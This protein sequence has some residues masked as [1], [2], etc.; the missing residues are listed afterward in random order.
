MRHSPRVAL[1]LIGFLMGAQFGAVFAAPVNCGA[2]RTL[3]RQCHC[4]GETNY[5]LA[6][7]LKYCERS[8]SAVG[9]SPE[10]ARWRDLTMA[11]LLR[12]ARAIF[13]PTG[14][15]CD[16]E[17]RK[18]RAIASH[19]LCYTH[20]PSSYCELPPRDVSLIY[21]IID[22]GDLFSHA[23]LSLALSIAGEC[24]THRRWL[25]ATSP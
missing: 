19:A 22:R 5:L 18:A 9:W 16:C 7:G 6:V 23:G 11:C 3:D 15:A 10:G 17:A 24:V 2:Y 8:R 14:G 1:A 20:H 13:A 21:G 4:P 12:E 25:S